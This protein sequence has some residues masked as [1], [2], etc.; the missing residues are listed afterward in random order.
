[1]AAKLPDAK[2]SFLKEAGLSDDVLNK[3]DENL[4]K[5]ASLA[6]ASGLESKEASDEDDTDGEI[7]GFDTSELQVTASDESEDEEEV[8]AVKETAKV[9]VAAKAKPY[10]KAEEIE[11]EMP[12]KKKVVAKKKEAAADVESSYVT[13]EEVAEALGAVLTPMLQTIETL[14]SHVAT[15]TKEIT[16]LKKEDAEKIAATKELTPTL[17]LSELI[18]RNV[19]GKEA[20]KV[21]GN[22]MLGK[23]GPKETEAPAGNAPTMVP[24]IN[25]IFTRTALSGSA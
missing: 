12:P 14:T 16:E 3:L 21:K 1:M 4:E 25:D 6:T 7:D 17:S 24:F 10:P 2:K 18:S 20:S 5:A 23:D 15:L 22:T 9:K 11:E 8:P 13:R 19:I